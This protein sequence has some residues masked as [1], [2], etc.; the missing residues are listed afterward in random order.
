MAKWL[1]MAALPLAACSASATGGANPTGTGGVRQFAVADFTGVSLRGSDDVDVRV[2]PAFS[3][4]A[5]GPPEVLDKLEIDRRGDML[6]VGRKRG[7]WR[8]WNDSGHVRVFVTMPR[9]ARASL[10][11]SGNMSIDQAEGQSFDAAIGGSGNIRIGKLTAQT[12]EF[13]VAGSGNLSASGSADKLDASIAG[14]GDI[15][16]AGLRVRAAEVSIAGSGDLR[17]SVNGDASVSLVGSG[18]V[19]LGPNA[20]CTTRKVGSGEVRCGK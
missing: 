10:G 13:S 7:D 15:D 3:V 19:D 17:A 1:L 9:I 18:D 11:G 5:E 14:S 4:R 8:S 20:R 16:A 2:G 6:V 12:A